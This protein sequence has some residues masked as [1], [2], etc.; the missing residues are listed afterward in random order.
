MPH[1]TPRLMESD[2]LS[3]L[4]KEWRAT[5]PL[6]PGFQKAVWRRMERADRQRFSIDPSAWSS[7]IQWFG[8]ILPRPAV[9]AAYVSIL[10]TLGV[11]G[12]WTHGRRANDRAKSELGDRY[13]RTLDPYLTPGQKFP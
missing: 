13:V 11:G 8:T 6:P 4:L 7:F 10:L 12:G 3:E 5:S 9:A 2:P 1:K